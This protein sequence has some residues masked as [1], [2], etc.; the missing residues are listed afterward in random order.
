MCVCVCEC[1]F[2][3]LIYFSLLGYRLPQRSTYWCSGNYRLRFII[4]IFKRSQRLFEFPS[5]MFPS[6]LQAPSFV[7]Y[8]PGFR[9][10][11]NYI[12]NKYG[13]PLTY[14]TENGTYISSYQY[15]YV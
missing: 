9:Q 5:D 11:L 8:P 10:I 12:K 4:I 3:K 14:I 6:C 13:N 15:K 2:S 7:Y 1:K